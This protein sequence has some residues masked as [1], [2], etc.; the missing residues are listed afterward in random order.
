MQGLNVLVDI[1][2][3]VEAADDTVGGAVRSDAI[4]Y[5]GVQ[6]RI[7]NDRVPAELRLQGVETA[8]SM[9][10]ILY[11]DQYPNVRTEDIVIPQSGTW[12]GQ[13]LRVTAVQHSSLPPGH[14]RAHIQLS[15]VHTDYAN[16][17]E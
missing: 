8:R 4:R 7:A 6:A 15:A 14:P 13:R 3:Q 9:E 2:A 16:R 11:P 17:E 1:F 12:A 5:A 10:I